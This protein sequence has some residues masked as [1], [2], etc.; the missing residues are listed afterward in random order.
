MIERCTAPTRARADVVVVGSGAGG[1]ACADRLSAAGLDVLV[2]E[3]GEHETPD[4]FT[5]REEDMLPR[6]F[7]DAGGRTTADGA[8]TVMQGKGVGGSTLHNLNLCKRVDDALLDRWSESVSGLAERLRRA[9]TAVESDLA[10]SQ[11]PEARLNRNN[12]LF[13]AGVEALGWAGGPLKHNRVGCIGSGFCEL[14][15]AYDAKMN[16]SRVLL[17][18]AMDQGARVWSNV[19]VDRIRTRLGRAVG[20][21][22]RTREG[23]QVVVEADA[24]VLSASATGTPALALASGV[25]DPHRQIGGHLRMHPG[26][27]VGAA[28]DETIEAWKGIPQAWECTE[29]LDPLD[30]AR[31]IWI[32]PVF[33]HPVTT[34]AMLPGFGAAHTQLMAHFPR[35]AACT[36]MLHDHSEGRVIAA[37]DGRPI[38]RYRLDAGDRHA[39]GEGLKAGARIFLAAGA[40]RAVLPMARPVEVTTRA[41]LD[42]LDLDVHRLD[43][44]LA[45]VHPMGS[46]RMG[47]DPRRS[48][49]D[50]W[51]R[52]RGQ[53]GLWVADG[54]LMPTSTGGPPQLTI[55]ALG[56]LVGDALAAEM[57]A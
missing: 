34:A 9:Y 44:A 4:T 55:Y 30:P 41:E 17:P 12:Q 27:T 52:V 45:A 48:A 38:L 46:M 49:C 5:Q 35:L 54:S 33:G 39:M 10:V 51:G 14:G 56:R 47:D 50:G 21:S 13:R 6:L 22:G 16:A 26:G 40:R 8:I 15:C 19:R 7:Q 28:F 20:V 32:V 36:P 23:H 3:M 11:V 1:S 18:R 57:G 43:P 31:R 25:P 42:R 24:V 53:P 29:H 2:L 37:P